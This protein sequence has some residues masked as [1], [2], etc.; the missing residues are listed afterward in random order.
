MLIKHN[1]AKLYKY[2]NLLCTLIFFVLIIEYLNYTS[3]H[4][5]SRL[6]REIPLLEQALYIIRIQC[7]SC[8]S[9]QDPNREFMSDN[10][11]ISMSFCYSSSLGPRGNH[12]ASVSAVM[13]ARLFGERSG[14]SEGFSPSLLKN[15]FVSGANVV[16]QVFNDTEIAKG[17]LK[18]LGLIEKYER[19]HLVFA[20]PSPEP[21]CDCALGHGLGRLLA[22]SLPS[23]RDKITEDSVIV[24]SH[25]GAF[26]SK[27]YIFNVLQ[28]PHQTWFFRSEAPFYLDQSWETTFTAMTARRW[29]QITDEASSCSELVS[30]HNV[31]LSKLY[32]PPWK[33]AQD[34]NSS[35]TEQ[36][37]STN[38]NIM[39]GVAAAEKF[40]T[41]R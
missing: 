27:P 28:S 12:R 20:A 5:R 23:L 22:H 4:R 16:L 37:S 29:R 10:V 6:K 1:N 18:V 19:S 7:Y 24:I 13:S 36:T 17:D 21:L 35:D 31:V 26:L 11:W 38:I 9:F 40:I 14:L 41:N 30:K 25:V 3:N 15:S 39:Q 34:A 33:Q 2:S 32:F 8:Y